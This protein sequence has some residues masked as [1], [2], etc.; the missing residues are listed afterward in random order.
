MRVCAGTSRAETHLMSGAYICNCMHCKDY[1][2][3]ATHN[4]TINIDGLLD[5]VCVGSALVAAFIFSRPN[6]LKASDPMIPD[7]ATEMA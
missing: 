4:T 2:F 5:K 3:L 6:H 7:V 1:L